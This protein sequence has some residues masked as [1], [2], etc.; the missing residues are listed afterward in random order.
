MIPKPEWV[1]EL[2]QR[3]GDQ[4]RLS[5]NEAVG[6]W[7]FDILCVDGVHRPQFWQ[8]QRNAAG[9]PLKPDPI[10]GL[11]PF[12][13]LD[14]ASFRE[15]CRNLDKTYLAAPGAAQTAQRHSQMMLAHNRGLRDK[16]RAERQADGEY[17]V[18][19]NW[20]RLTDAPF[21]AGG[22]ALVSPIGGSKEN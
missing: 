4:V 1:A 20:R 9:T 13:D 6:R 2:R 11:L 7:S 5:W 22:I 19:D 12:R 16:V 14:D 21:S 3:Y 18:K 10:S 15:A 17:W 8:W